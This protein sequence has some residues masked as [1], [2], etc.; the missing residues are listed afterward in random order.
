MTVFLKRKC[1][2]WTGDCQVFKFFWHKNLMRFQNE[3]SVLNFLRHIVDEP[4]TDPFLGFGLSPARPISSISFANRF[5]KQTWVDYGWVLNG[6]VLLDF[7]NDNFQWRFCLVYSQWVMI[8]NSKTRIIFIG[9]LLMRRE[10][11]G[12]VTGNTVKRTLMTY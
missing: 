9:L 5:Q 10:A 4:W 8:A 12:L 7:G 6:V 11:R 3:N 1:K 2:N